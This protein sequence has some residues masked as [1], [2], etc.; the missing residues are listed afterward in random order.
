MKYTYEQPD[1]LDANGVRHLVQELKQY[2]LNISDGN[3]DITQYAAKNELAQAVNSI[4]LSSYAKTT[5][6]PS[7]E[8]YADKEY[9]D[10]AVA[11]VATGGEVN[12]LNYYTKQEAFVRAPHT[13]GY[14]S[15]G[16]G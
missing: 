5:D 13:G 11:N 14:I 3:I 15:Y 8:G 6:I 7:L 9:V 2:I 10:N 16:D 12:L 1:Y 4:D